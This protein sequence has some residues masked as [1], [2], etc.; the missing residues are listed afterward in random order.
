MPIIKPR[1]QLHRNP[2]NRTQTQN[3]HEKWINFRGH[4]ILARASERSLSAKCEI[5]IARDANLELN[6]KGQMKVRKLTLEGKVQ[7]AGR[8]TAASGVDCIK[9]NGLLEVTE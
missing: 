1:S 6:F 4:S 9:G 2:K 3:S 5:T 7:P 8:Y